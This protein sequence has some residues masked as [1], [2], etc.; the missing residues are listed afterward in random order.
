MFGKVVFIGFAA[1]IVL[2]MKCAGEQVIVKQC[3][4]FTKEKEEECKQ[5][6]YEKQEF[7]L[8]CTGTDAH[9]VPET[10][11]A[12][13]ST[14]L[15]GTICVDNQERTSMDKPCDTDIKLENLQVA[16]YLRAAAT[17]TGFR[18]TVLKISNDNDLY[19]T[20]SCANSDKSKGGYFSVTIKKGQESSSA[21]HIRPAL[22]TAAVI[23][24]I[25]LG[26]ALG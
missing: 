17:D 23:G 14:N 9:T 8:D 2:T 18:V 7:I 5:T 22:T 26:G 16:D 4:P 24:L 20:G 13:T 10:L 19:Y 6:I 21:N 1:V 15:T 12:S 11:L 25:G 3:G